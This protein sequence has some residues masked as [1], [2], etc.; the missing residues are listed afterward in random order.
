MPP[1]EQ[2]RH[3]RLLLFAAVLLTAAN[4][5]STITGVG[6]LLAQISADL[7]TT[8]AA[9]GLLAAI[10][11]IAFALVS[12]LAHALGMRFGI[13]AVVFCSLIALGAAPCGALSR[14]RA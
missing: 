6:P 9:L 8:E 14:E 11:L 2:V 7:G 4:L 3:P 12:P 5:R 13:S 10:P 1:S